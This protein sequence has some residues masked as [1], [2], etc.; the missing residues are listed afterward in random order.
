MKR[1]TMTA[2]VALA[3]LASGVV[4]FAAPPVFAGQDQAPDRQA[5]AVSAADR[6][7]AGGLDALAKGPE[8]VYAR[9]L[10]TP[11][12]NDLYSVSYQR[13]WRGV[14][15]V[16]G[17]A[18]VL[19]NGQGQV[20]AT[21][22]G[23]SAAVAVPTTTAKI[24]K[25]AAERTARSAQAS[26]SKVQPSRLV[27]KVTEDKPAL[28]WEQLLVGT[29]T[30]GSPSHLTVWVDATTGAVL[31]QVEDA[32]AGSLNSELNGQVTIT[33]SKSGSTYRLLDTTR[34]GLQCADYSTNQVFSK[35]TDSWGTG[36]GTSK[37]TGCGDVLYAAQQEWNM[38]K[39]WLGRNGHNGSGRS[40]PAK[41]GLNQLNAY[42]DGS[43]VT[44]GKNSA[45]K[46]IAS[47][48]VVGHEYGH[49]LDQNTPGGTSREAGLGEA[50]G[51][52]FGA[53]T[54]AYANNAKDRP[55]YLVGE[56]VDLQGRGPI[57]NM[58]NPSLV[59]NDPNCYSSSIPNT[60]VHKAA[61]P[62]NHWF[63][64]LAEGSNPGGG[65]PTSPTCNNT[66]VTGVGIQ[67]AGKIFYGGMLLKTSGM[68]YKKYR[69]TTLTAAKNLDATCGLYNK[70]KA[71]WNAIS[72]P[73]QA[74]EPTC[75]A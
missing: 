6:A 42:W 7:A 74:G 62:L 35:S 30:D 23:T 13:T 61:G 60:E 20:K 37:E 10:V 49:G 9:D 2:G 47:M 68:T 14:P 52:I 27:V 67:T 31:D 71:A 73:A 8:E 5:V 28:A 3:V 50:T 32:A 29:K 46:W 18:T 54:E 25:A 12:L 72:L 4:A 11:Y 33:T 57:R 44:I 1:T 51:D 66:A 21:V 48:D 75:T 45:G 55:D 53:L 26:T 36:S 17:D 64:L 24:T 65:K 59:N 34:P 15:V 69:V 39:D 58:Y 38:L 19:V 43:T 22:A 70:T 41:V 16:G 56:T 63:Y 40:W